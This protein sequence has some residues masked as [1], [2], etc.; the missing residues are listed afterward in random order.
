[1]EKSDEKRE[2]RLRS[3]ADTVEHKLDSKLHQR[4]RAWDERFKAT[5]KEVRESKA[6]SSARSAASDAGLEASRAG[7][8]FS[9]SAAAP[10]G[11]LGVAQSVDPWAALLR[12]RAAST[13]T[14]TLTA[15]K[16]ATFE[17]SK[18]EIRGFV[19]DCGRTERPSP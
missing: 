6:A 4:D 13:P 10:A 15:E 7:S 5:E 16:L 2:L 9:G 8:R 14:G 1:M 18:L 12:S 11:S 17:L 3:F 19:D